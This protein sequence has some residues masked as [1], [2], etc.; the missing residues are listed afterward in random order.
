MIYFSLQTNLQC[1]INAPSEE[2]IVFIDPLQWLPFTKSDK[3]WYRCKIYLLN[4]KR[5]MS[6]GILLFEQQEI[7]SNFG[8]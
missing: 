4:R 5:H 7:V 2:A 3:S 8:R 6:P 1:R